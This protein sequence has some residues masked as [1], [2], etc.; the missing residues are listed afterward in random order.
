MIIYTV[1]RHIEDMTIP[2]SSFCSRKEAEKFA[3]VQMAY[4]DKNYL[5]SIAAWD[6]M[7]TPIVPCKDKRLRL[8]K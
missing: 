1:L 7:L 2:L 8:V 5:Y 4:V 6:T 3:E